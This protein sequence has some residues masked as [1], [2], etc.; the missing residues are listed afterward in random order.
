MIGTSTSSAS[1]ASGWRSCT[2]HESDPATTQLVNSASDELAHSLSELRELAQGIHPGGGSGLRGLRDR[3]EA[4]H[5]HL[6]VHSPSGAGT[7]IT[8][9]IPYEP[10]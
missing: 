1:R 3:V 6:H 2:R 9:E 8:A 4:L 5:G 7:V 10:S